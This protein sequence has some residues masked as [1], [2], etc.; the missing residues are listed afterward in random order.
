MMHIG[1]VS[2][3]PAPNQCQIGAV[4]CSMIVRQSEF[5]GK[6]SHSESLGEKRDSRLACDDAPYYMDNSHLWP[7]GLLSTAFTESVSTDPD[8]SI[9]SF[10]SCHIMH[11]APDLLCAISLFMQ[12]RILRR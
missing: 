9:A 11:N 7:F 5:L 6:S 12:M 4:A 10:S 2:D 8:L 3:W 1:A